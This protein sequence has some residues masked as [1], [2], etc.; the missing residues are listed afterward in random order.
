[1]IQ[2]RWKAN[3]LRYTPQALQTGR[4]LLARV[5]NMSENGTSLNGA[6]AKRRKVLTLE[7][8][9]PH[10]KKMEYAVRGPIVA[11]AGEIEQELKSVSTHALKY[12]LFFFQSGY[13]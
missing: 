3:P 2:I 11:R 4:Q 5:V 9:N 13:L 6:V 10:I 8:M 7:N 12:F 1:M